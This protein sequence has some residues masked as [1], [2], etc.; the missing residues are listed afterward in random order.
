MASSR[1]ISTNKSNIS[2]IAGGI[3]AELAREN[4]PNDRNLLTASA[5]VNSKYHPAVVSAHG[6][7]LQAGA[8]HIVTNNRHVVPGV[9]FTLEEMRE[10]TRVAG[11]LAAEAKQA[12]NCD[13]E[14]VTICGR[15]PPLMPSYRSDRIMKH[16]EAVENY[17][18]I[19]EA[20]LPF[21]DVYL[22]DSMSSSE[23]A[24][25]AYDAVK[26]LGKPVW[27][28]FALNQQGGLRSGE[29]LDEA[30]QN[31]LQ[32]CKQTT[33]DGPTQ[34]ILTAILFNCSQPEDITRAIT[35]VRQQPKLWMEFEHRELRLGGFA[36][37]ISPNSTAGAME[38]KLVT[39]ALRSDLDKE[40]F[41]GF[42]RKWLESGATI[43]G[44]CCSIAPAYIR[45]L[46]ECVSGEEGFQP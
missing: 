34:Y 42:E 21:V 10:Y 33:D 31:V 32:R 23:E 25:M 11:R 6:V 2:I 43:V 19:G 46:Q 4:V 29:S 26:H 8:S 20:L 35:H 15:L 17:L 5:L 38:E 1:T 30:I 9:G 16:A 13:E 44:G 12:A 45:C 18:T 40:V 41:K 3:G 36:D 22:A 39:G 7:F 14:K 37:P 28:S 27:L 24:I